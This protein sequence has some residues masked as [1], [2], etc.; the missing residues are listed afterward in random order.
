MYNIDRF[1]DLKIIL[2]NSL[3]GIPIIA[4]QNLLNKFNM[5]LRYNIHYN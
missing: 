1:L 3:I 5:N 2:D 4:K